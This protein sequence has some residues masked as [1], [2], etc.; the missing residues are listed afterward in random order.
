MTT[1]E[2][3]IKKKSSQQNC[4]LFIKLSTEQFKSK[5]FTTQMTPEQSQNPFYTFL[6]S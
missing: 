4:Q 1:S 3:F 5:T 6:N 2:I